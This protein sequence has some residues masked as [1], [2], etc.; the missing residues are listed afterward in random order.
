MSRLELSLSSVCVGLTRGL[1][2]FEFQSG[3]TCKVNGVSSEERKDERSPSR[4]R[5]R[6]PT[7]LAASPKQ[8]GA[9]NIR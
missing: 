3:Q 1:S 2:W 4:Q 8:N 5:D 7:P 9:G 6:T